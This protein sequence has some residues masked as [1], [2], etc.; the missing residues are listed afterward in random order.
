M[1]VEK[2]FLRELRV[3]G[4]RARRLEGRA[5]V[6]NQTT[7]IGNFRERIAPGAFAPSLT[8]NPDIL[9]LLDHDPAKVLGRTKS[10]TLSLR[11]GAD[12]LQFTIEVPETGAG[13]DA[14]V[15]AQRGDLGGASIGFRVTQETVADDGTR[16][17][18]QAALLEISVVSSWPA[19][20]G[21]S[22]EARRRGL[23][24]PV[25]APRLNRLRR[26]LETI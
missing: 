6:Y 23:L 13:K 24:S 14:L 9:A 8:G 11:D 22:V 21:T 16:V 10:G 19:Y 17:I 4:E 25:L 12:H 15:L 3:A 20:A 1:T 5:A 2:R 7:D 26:Y 18:Q